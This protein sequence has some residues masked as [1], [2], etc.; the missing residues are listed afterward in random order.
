ML[1]ATSAAFPER[2]SAAGGIQQADGGETPDSLVVN[3]EYPGGHTV[4]LAASLAKSREPV[5]V[6][7]GRTAALDIRTD[8]VQLVSNE[9]YGSPEKTVKTPGSRSHLDDWFEC[10]RSRGPCV[11]NEEIGYRAMVA[12]GMAVEAYRSGATICFN[13]ADETRFPSPPRVSA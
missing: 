1:T 13:A 2:V 10:I 9:G 7:R 11:C 8:R 5:V 3:A 12:V 6:I 4:V